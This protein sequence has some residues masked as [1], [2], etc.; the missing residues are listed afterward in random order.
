M[1]KSSTTVLPEALKSGIESM[2][3]MNAND[4][5]VH[6]T[7]KPTQLNAHTYTQGTNIDIVP[8]QERNLPHEAWHVVQH[9]QGRVSPTAQIH[10]ELSTDEESL[11]T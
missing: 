7:P 3:D 4:V 6:I 9:K 11:K 5:P 2:S 10:V 1:E 8:E